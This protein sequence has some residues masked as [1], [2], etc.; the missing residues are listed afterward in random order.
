MGDP[1][2]RLFT[3]TSHDKTFFKEPTK[4]LRK[5]NLFAS[6]HFNPLVLRPYTGHFAIEICLAHENSALLAA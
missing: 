1:I 3:M 2:I 6:I 5:I 4:F